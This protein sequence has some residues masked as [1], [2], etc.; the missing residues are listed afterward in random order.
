[1]ASRCAVS[2]SYPVA[3]G[4]GLVRG[5]VLGVQPAGGDFST[6]GLEPG[7]GLFCHLQ[8]VAGQRGRSAGPVPG[9]GERAG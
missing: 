2:G 1:M 9:S 5:G 7:R 8:G 4:Q 6:A 3:Q